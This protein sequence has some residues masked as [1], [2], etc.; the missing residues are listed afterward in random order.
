MYPF[1]WVLK[2]AGT[3]CIL[4]ALNQENCIVDVL[5][6]NSPELLDILDKYF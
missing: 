3:T 4:T 1:S 6:L 5:C 2:H